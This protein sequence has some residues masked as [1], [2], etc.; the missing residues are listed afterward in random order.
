[1]IVVS[2]NKVF[3]KT[4]SGTVKDLT[5]DHDT[6]YVHPTSKVC[7]YSYTHPGTKQCA[8]GDCSTISGYTYS[9][10]I[11]NASSSGIKTANGTYVGTG[12]H[13]KNN[14]V[15]ITIGFS[16]K[17]VIVGANSP[18]GD[19]GLLFWVIGMTRLIN[20]YSTSSGLALG[21]YAISYRVRQ[22][23]LGIVMNIV[24]IN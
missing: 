22:C 16:P 15:T 8:G 9:Q 14:P 7:N 4:M 17:F 24:V 2:N 5:E 6:V 21:V 20:D 18:G 1:M 23:F 13:G 12:K 11:S 19:P 10:I 3:C